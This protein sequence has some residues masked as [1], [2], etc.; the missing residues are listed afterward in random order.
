MAATTTKKKSKK[1]V[2]AEKEKEIASV[3]EDSV[4]WIECSTGDESDV[5]SAW[6]TSER[7]AT[8]AMEAVS[9]LKAD[10]M[11]NPDEATRLPGLGVMMSGEN[12]CRY[13][14]GLCHKPT[15]TE[16]QKLAIMGVIPS[17]FQSV[18][19]ANSVRYTN[20]GRAIR[21]DPVYYVY[22]PA[23]DESN[24]WKPVWGDN[25]RPTGRTRRQYSAGGWKEY[26]EFSASATSLYLPFCQMA[27]WAVRHLWHVRFS[28]GPD[29]RGVMYATSAAGVRGLFA[30]RDKP[31]GRTRRAALLHWVMS[32]D[33]IRIVEDE[34]ISISVRNHMRGE[35]HF[36]WFGLHGEVLA[37]PELTEQQRIMARE[38]LAK[39]ER[40]E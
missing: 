22:S 11:A 29:S 18:F 35:K 8:A 7:T 36:D 25:G 6:L 15:M 38:G 12:K 37:P 10:Y 21:C 26:Q 14:V 27:N 24:P 32:H 2:K 30:M 4:T 17:P 23:A 1:A 40:G 31:E 3:I 39:R 16:R 20:D 28:V 34:E 33:R 13:E 5:N 9:L 19:R